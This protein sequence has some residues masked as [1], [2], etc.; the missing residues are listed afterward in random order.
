MRRRS[1]PSEPDQIE[2]CTSNSIQQH[3]ATNGHQSDA[4]AGISAVRHQCAKKETSR[5]QN[6]GPDE[7]NRRGRPDRE[8]IEAPQRQPRGDVHERE[9][10]SVRVT[11]RQHQSPHLIIDIQIP[12]ELEAMQRL[13][14][15]AHE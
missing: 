15:Q 11:E 5:Q 3:E 14:Q 6:G 12:A 2:C 7:A 13:E 8:T 4:D 1:G 9:Q 10:R